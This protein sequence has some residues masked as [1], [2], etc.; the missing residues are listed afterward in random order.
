MGRFAGMLTFAPAPAPAPADLPLAQSF[1]NHFHVTDELVFRHCN[2]TEVVTL[3]TGNNGSY[4][5]VLFFCE[6]EVFSF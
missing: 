1:D 2:A 4:Q 5:C 3:G 6:G